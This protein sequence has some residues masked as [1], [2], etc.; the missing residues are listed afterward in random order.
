MT[1]GIAVVSIMI[2]TLKSLPLICTFLI[3]KPFHFQKEGLVRFAR[4]CKD[5][6]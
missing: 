6:R 2:L 5:I 3:I 1:L 4:Y